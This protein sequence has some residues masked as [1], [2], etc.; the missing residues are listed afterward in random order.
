[1]QTSIPM[2]TPNYK[3]GWLITNKIA[4]LSHFHSEITQ[5]DLMGVFTETQR[6]LKDTQ[7]PFQ[8]II[9]NRL[10]PINKIY[11]LAELQQSS[12]LL[13]HPLLQYIVIVKPQHIELQPEHLALETRHGIHLKNVASI[14][15]AI[16]YVGR[17]STDG[18]MADMD[19][20]FFPNA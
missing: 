13:S 19:T 11:T 17:M 12:P 4:A 5:E 1:M 7:K 8:V 16:E 15:E 9:D 10:A 3:V 2:R 18:D 20:S 6:L 14:G